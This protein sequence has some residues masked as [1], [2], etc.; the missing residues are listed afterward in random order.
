VRHVAGLLAAA[1]GEIAKA[2]SMRLVRI[3]TD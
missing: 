1:A 2:T 3:R